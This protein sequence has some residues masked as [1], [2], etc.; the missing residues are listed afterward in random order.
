MNIT[1]LV[2]MTS[3]MLQHPLNG[4]TIYLTHLLYNIQQGIRQGGVLSADL[5]KIYID[6]LLH[7][8]QHSSLGIQIGDVACPATACADEVTLNSTTP[9]DAQ[10]LI[11]IAYDYSL[12]QR[13]MLQPAK[14]AILEIGKH[15][16]TNSFHMGETVMSIENKATHLGIQRATST[17]ETITHTINE[18]LNKSTARQNIICPKV[19]FFI[20]R[21]SICKSLHKLNKV[22]PPS[23]SN[24]PIKFE[25]C[26][27]NRN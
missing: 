7:R 8:L 27:P 19:C 6:P 23:N 24:P 26:G 21:M 5:Y 3:N 20:L 15:K 18:N 2:G 1:L 16:T 14:S 10:I 9:E 13:Y 11:D 22:L 12:K 4:T 17:K 25:Y